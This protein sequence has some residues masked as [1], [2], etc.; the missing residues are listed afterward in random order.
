MIPVTSNR[1]ILGPS[2]LS[3]DARGQEYLEQLRD[4]LSDEELHEITG[5]TLGNHYSVTKL[6]W[7]RDHQP[8]VYAKADFFLSWGGLVNFML[9]AEP[10]ADYSLANRTLLFDLNRRAWSDELLSWAGLE[11]SKLPEPV[12]SGTRFGEVSSHMAKE[13]GLPRNTTIVAGAHDQCSNAV[14]CG[15]IREGAAMFGMG[16]YLCIVPVYRHRRDPRRMIERGLN[17]EH[18]ALPD[19]FVSFIYNMS[20]AI[21]KWFRDTFAA[22]EHRRAQSLCQD[23]YTNLFFELPDSPSQVTVLPHFI[24][25]GSLALLWKLNAGISSRASSRLLCS[26]YGNAWTSSQGWASLSRTTERLAAVPSPMLGCSCLRISWI[27]PSC[28]Q[29]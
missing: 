17:T 13:L 18:H 9:G 4:G 5:N 24:P 26:P 11:R 21:V 3:F 27:G 19:L 16:T 8:E 1:R 20:G 14:G 28:V 22:E 25:T 23:T 2:I 12:P 29:A 7:T 6:M 15:V 10:A